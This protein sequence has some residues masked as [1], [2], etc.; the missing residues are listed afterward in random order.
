LGRL[1]WFCLFHTIGIYFPWCL[2]YNVFTDIN[3]EYLS[4]KR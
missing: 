4:K 1:F 2:C 3:S